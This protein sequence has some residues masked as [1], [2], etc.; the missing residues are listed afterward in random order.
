GCEPIVASR[1]RGSK[2]GTKIRAVWPTGCGVYPDRI[3]MV[4]LVDTE[5]CDTMTGTFKFKDTDRKKIRRG[6]TATR[7]DETACQ[8]GGI[9]ASPL[10]QSRI[11]YARG[12]NV[13]TCH[14][15]ASP[16]GGLDL[17][18]EAAHLNLI[19]VPAVNAGAAAAG[20]KRVVPS[21]AS[22]SFLYQKLAG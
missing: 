2:R 11:F 18:Q 22:A 10:I 21:N 8:D 1:I 7:L 14:S 13:A 20:K 19:D 5:T 6:F 3:V 9:R 4:A 17:T 12:C 16:R 15:S